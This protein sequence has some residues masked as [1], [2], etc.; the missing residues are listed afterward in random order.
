MPPSTPP[1]YWQQ[2]GQDYGSLS[3]YI[4]SLFGGAGSSGSGSGS[5]S[6]GY[7]DPGGKKKLFDVGDVNGTITAWKYGPDGKTKIPVL[8]TNQQLYENGLPSNQN[9]QEQNAYRRRMQEADRLRKGLQGDRTE[10]AVKLIGAQTESTLQTQAPRLQSAETQT[11]TTAK[12]NRDIAA[13]D[14]GATRYAA[15][16]Q[17]ASAFETNTQTNNTNRL[18]T[19]LGFMADQQK[20]ATELYAIDE[21]SRL[22]ELNLEFQRQSQDTSDLMALMIRNDQIRK[23]QAAAIREGFAGRRTAQLAQIVAAFA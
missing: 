15:N 23:E 12:A 8:L 13:L 14:A 19:A 3:P 16:Q 20:N 1:S 4:Y 6:G 11:E 2:L 17:R 5:G 21:K 22:A 10:N 18:S 7:K 9:I